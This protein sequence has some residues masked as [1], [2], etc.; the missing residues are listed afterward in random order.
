MADAPRAKNVDAQRAT[1]SSSN[2]EAMRVALDLLRSRRTLTTQELR[3]LNVSSED[4]AD[5]LKVSIEDGLIRWRGIF[6]S[7]GIMNLVK[8]EGALQVTEDILD[9]YQCVA[10]DLWDLVQQKKVRM[11]VREDYTQRHAQHEEIRRRLPTDVAIVPPRGEPTTSLHGLYSAT[12]Q[13]HHQRHVY[14]NQASGFA[15]FYWGDQYGHWRNGWV[16]AP[17]VGA[18]E[19]FAFALGNIKSPEK[20]QKW[21]ANAR[22]ELSIQCVTV[23]FLSWVLYPMHDGP[24]PW[25]GHADVAADLKQMWRKQVHLPLGWM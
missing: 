23:D 7:D 8:S 15:I 22:K 2:F 5:N 12:P 6:D 18:K 1:S 24:P 3:R 9:A 11:L 19:K 14:I 13:L 16:L 20:A 4:F 21:M 25:H 17:K 10:N